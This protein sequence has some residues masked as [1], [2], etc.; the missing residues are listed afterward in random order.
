MTR[1]RRRELLIYGCPP[2]YESGGEGG[3]ERRSG[4]WRGA[5]RSDTILALYGDNMTRAK[6]HE[7]V[8]VLTSEQAS[9]PRACAR[10]TAAGAQATSQTERAPT[11]RAMR[12]SIDKATQSLV[13]HWA[14]DDDQSET[15]RSHTLASGV[16]SR[17]RHGMMMIF[18][19]VM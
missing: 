2:F 12:A 19:F 9:P 1:R 5:T 3:K 10:S 17:I 7:R 14:G 18:Y 4:L 11:P 15:S 6:G 13:C 16:R 8:R